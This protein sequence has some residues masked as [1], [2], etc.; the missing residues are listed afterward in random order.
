M[1]AKEIF[2][3]KDMLFGVDENIVDKFVGGAVIKHI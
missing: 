1:R 2:I 3:L